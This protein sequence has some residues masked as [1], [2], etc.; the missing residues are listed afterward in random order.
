MNAAMR[1]PCCLKVKLAR[2]CAIEQPSLEH[3]VVN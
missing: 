2:G 1:M 3:A